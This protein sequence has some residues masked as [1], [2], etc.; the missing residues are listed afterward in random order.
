MRAAGFLLTEH[1]QGGPL[2]VVRLKKQL[3]IAQIRASAAKSPPAR[4][5][6]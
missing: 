1:E 2:A 6:P 5:S 3:L 4:A